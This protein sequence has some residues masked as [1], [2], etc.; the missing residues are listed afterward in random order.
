MSKESSGHRRRRERR[1]AKQREAEKGRI[2]KLLAV[3]LLAAT[4]L[5]GTPLLSQAPYGQEKTEQVATGDISI[6]QQVEQILNFYA[7]ELSAAGITEKDQVV[8]ET[9]RAS[10]RIH[11]YTDYQL[12]IESL[13]EFLNACTNLTAQNRISMENPGG[14]VE[15]S[16]VL[17]KFPDKDRYAATI[18]V[19]P[20]TF[21]MDH[22]LVEQYVAEAGYNIDNL[23][24]VTVDLYDR[25]DLEEKPESIA[26]VRVSGTDYRQDLETLAIEFSQNCFQVAQEIGPKEFRGYTVGQEVFG[27]SA[28]RAAA[29]W[30]LNPGISVQDLCADLEE[31]TITEPSG[32]RRTTLFPFCLLDST[33]GF[34]EQ[35]P[36]EPMLTK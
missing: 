1:E 2:L 20:D 32:G 16:V 17:A 23:L 21:G 30:A 22:P 29:H 10:I 28:G 36:Q 8:L 5:V 6:S 15:R 31:R 3:A 11:N 27:N 12:N 13:Q 35:L 9:E 19:I 24:G 33:K 25:Y 14:G 4:V 18:F 34:I 26:L 7:Q